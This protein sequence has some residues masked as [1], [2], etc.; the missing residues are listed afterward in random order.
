MLIEFDTASLTQLPLRLPILFQRAVNLAV[1]EN[2]K[3]HKSKQKADKQDVNKL[4]SSIALKHKTEK[5]ELRKKGQELEEEM[6]AMK[7]LLKQKK[8]E[9]KATALLLK[10]QEQSHAA[11]MKVQHCSVFVV[12]SH[13][14]QTVLI[15]LMILILNSPDCQGESKRARERGTSC[16]CTLT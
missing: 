11:E 12:L 6:I 2:N 3:K 8:K 16:H 7:K 9:K 14:R 1:H 10:G 5:E 15:K 13:C 4:L